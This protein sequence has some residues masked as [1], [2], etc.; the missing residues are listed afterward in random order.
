MEDESISG[1]V[2]MVITDDE[3]E[4]L[5]GEVFK[6]WR[7]SACATLCLLSIHRGAQRSPAHTA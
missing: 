1:T 4:Q 2:T 3:S 7:K 5:G 6:T